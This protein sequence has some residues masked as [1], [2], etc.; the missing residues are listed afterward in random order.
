[1]SRFD[2]YMAIP[3]IEGGRDFSGVDCFGLYALIVATELG[4]PVPDPRVSF[5]R[6]G[7]RTVLAAFAAEVARGAWIEVKT[8][9]IFDAVRMSGFHVVRGEAHKSE[10]HV[11][12]YDGT[13]YV[14]HTELQ[15]GPRRM[16]VEDPEIGPRL[17]GFFR[18]A[19]LLNLPL[20]A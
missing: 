17:R 7:A 6:N 16:P 19:V 9:R 11:G 12:C 10:S 8:P 13:G 1:M 14:I 15:T 2:K 18:P 5:G 4:L 20:A 3:F